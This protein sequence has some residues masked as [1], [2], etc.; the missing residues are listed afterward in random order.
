MPIDVVIVGGGLAGLTAA[1]ALQTRGVQVAV[2]EREA[3]FGGRAGSV[4]DAVTGDTVD[5]GPHVL[6]SEYPNMRWLL[7][8]LGTAG[9]IL[10]DNDRFMTLVTHGERNALRARRL[11]PPLHFLPNPWRAPRLGL[12]DILSNLRVT[13]QGMRS[14]EAQVLALDGIGARDFLQRCGVSAHLID[15][16]WATISMTI[17]NVPLERCSAGALMRFFRVLLGRNDIR[18]GFPTIPLADLFVPVLAARLAAACARLELQ[19]RAEAIA[20]TNNGFALRLADGRA[21]DA[22]FCIAAL[23]PA[24]LRALLPPAWCATGSLSALD[25]FAPCEYVS[26]Y[27]WFTRKLTQARAWSRTWSPTTLNYDFYDLSNIRPGWAARPSLVASN[28]IYSQRL[29]AMSDDAIVA[30]TVRELAEFAPGAD[31]A[32]VRHARVH[33]I[34]FAIPCPVVGTETKRPATHTSVPGLFLAG[35]WTATGLP[36]SMEGAVRSGWLAAQ[37]VLAALGRPAAL[38]RDLNP[39]TGITGLVQRHAGFRPAKPPATHG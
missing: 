8:Q 33:R 26:T 4:R 30:A 13:W 17:L 2:I 39:A 31:M 6:L 12:R 3:Q 35:D 19:A 1:F 15:T 16:Y 29:P 34:P 7:E 36:A 5:V 24:D 21:L 22:R 18:M 38:A 9:D 28:I 14:N 37:A 20:R 32:G 27:V 23:P 25:A 11:P 10:W